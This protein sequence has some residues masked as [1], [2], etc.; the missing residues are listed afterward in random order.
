MAAETGLI[1][2]ITLALGTSALGGYLAHRVGQP[3]LLGYLVT[4]LVIDPSGL[5]LLR[6]VEQVQALTAIGITLSSTAV[7]LK[8]LTERG[9]TGTV[10]GQIC[11]PC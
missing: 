2:D 5:G 4:G 3:V 6:D 9:E 10:H 7:V 1:V 8:T 11:W